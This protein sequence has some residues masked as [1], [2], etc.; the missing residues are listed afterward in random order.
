MV[1]MYT[2]QRG[3]DGQLHGPKNKKVW[4]TFAGRLAGVLWAR[5]EATKR[6]FGPETTKTVQILMDGAKSLRR[7][8]KKY[9]PKALLTLDIYHAVEK[10]W[11]LGRHY[12]PGGSKEL[13]GFVEELKEY[14]YSGRAS[15][16]SRISA[17]D[18]FPLHPA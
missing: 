17:P 4:G 3:V 13:Q 12:Q 16:F 18:Q 5:S 15:A 7:L 2:L 8:M 11:A 6:G 9:F 10:L 14:L 1:V